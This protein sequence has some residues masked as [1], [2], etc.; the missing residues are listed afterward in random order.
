MRARGSE[1]L[2]F[3]QLGGAYTKRMLTKRDTAVACVVEYTTDYRGQPVLDSHPSKG[4]VV[5]SFLGRHEQLL[6][7]KLALANSPQ[8]NYWADASKR[9]QRQLLLFGRPPVKTDSGCTGT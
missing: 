2:K 9:L 1:M 3:N 6:R 4:D 8:H 7:L 5:S